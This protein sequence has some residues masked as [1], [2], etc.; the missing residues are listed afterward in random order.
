MATCHCRQDWILANGQATDACT[1]IGC[2]QA[3]AWKALVACIHTGTGSRGLGRAKGGNGDA[4]L[5]GQTA[6]S[7]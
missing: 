1:G 2:W 3:S 4:R 7:L 5:G 6:S